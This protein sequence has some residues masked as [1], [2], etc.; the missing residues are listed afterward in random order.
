MNDSLV[1][2]LTSQTTSRRLA[3]VFWLNASFTVIEFFGGYWTDS[4]A[5]MADAVHDLGDSFVIGYLATLHKK[6]P[7]AP[8][9]TAIDDSHY[10]AR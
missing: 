7:T 5:I 2:R 9:P 4:T 8:I 6:M 10:W 1:N 3:L